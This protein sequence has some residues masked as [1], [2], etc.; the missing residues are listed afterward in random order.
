MGKT[1]KFTDSLQS[2]LGHLSIILRAIKKW[3]GPNQYLRTIVELF[4]YL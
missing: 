3:T 1:I 4:Q 2:F